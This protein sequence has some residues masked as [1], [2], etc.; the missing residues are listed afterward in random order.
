MKVAFRFARWLTAAAIGL[1]PVL[2]VHAQSSDSPNSAVYLYKGADRNQKLLQE[3]KKEGTLLW[4]TSL[5][6][7]ESGPM[8]QAFEKKYGIKVEVWR[9]TSDKVVQRAI[10]EGSAKRH[11]FDVVET[12]G[13]EVEMIA[14]EN[15]L[16]PFHS[17]YLADLPPFAI[18][19]HRMWAAD[20]MSVYGVG[21]NTNAVKRE[22]LP[23]DFSGFL[24]PKWKGKIGVEATDSEWMSAMLKAMG[25]ERGMNFMRKLAEMRPDIRKGHILL[26]ELIMAGE[27]PV[28]LTTYQS[29]ATSLKRK[30]GPIDWVAL[31]PIVVRPQAIGVARNAPHPHA[32]LLF[33]DFVLSPEGQA[34]LESMGRSPTSTKI[35]S[36]FS[37]RKYTMVDPVS[38]LDEHEKWQ[39][40]WDDLFLKK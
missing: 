39:K 21:F 20:R 40:I 27:V 31:D 4:Y 3:G 35:K 10:T 16:A 17:P 1:A 38:V 13:P 29:N 15:L 22:Q 11:A 28:G 2:G 19:K 37:G 32:A 33:V 34:L 25:E 12:N 36:E 7:S 8:A 14:R 6:P 26:A 5:A 18:P 23:K 24:D 9:S 30:G